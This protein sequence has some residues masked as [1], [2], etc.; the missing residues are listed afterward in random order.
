MTTNPP[1]RLYEMPISD[2]PAHP[3]LQGGAIY[4]WSSGLLLLA[5]T[6]ILTRPTHSLAAT[7]RIAAREPYTIEV[8]GRTLVTRASLVSP[9]AVRNRIIAVNSDIAL[10]YLP[11]DMPEYAGLRAVLKDQRL[12]DLPFEPFRPLL[13]KIREALVA[14]LPGAEIKA[15]LQAVVQ[16]VTGDATLK[17]QASDPR[18]EQARAILD[19]LPLDEFDLKSLARQVRLSPSRL[20]ELFKREVGLTVG[21]YV[22]WQAVWR[23]IALWKEGRK[24]TDL[25]IECGFHDLAHADKAFTEAF[26]INPTTVT[27]PRYFK[28]VHCDG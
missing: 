12:I 22:R 21:E 13:P 26:G 19:Q 16:A 24:F 11:I 15:L 20:R 8:E 18:V 3:A 1:Q 10:F 9:K 25:A 27:D 2:Q 5:P 7:L 6:L 17:P 28:L 14:A 4:Y 23:M